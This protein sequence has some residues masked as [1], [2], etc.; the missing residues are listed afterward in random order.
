MFIDKYIQVPETSA[1]EIFLKSLVDV[2]LK[3]TRKLGMAVNGGL[4]MGENIDCQIKEVVTAAA[5]T[6]V[7]VSHTLKR[8][9]TG[10]MV[11]N[12]DK[13]AIIYA[14]GTAWT[15]TNIYIKS[16]AATTTVK[17]LIF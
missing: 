5:N 6:E 11:V 4:K 9:P 15:A 7:A 10:F 8:T 1:P 3:Y 14:S 2:L 17:L 12:L 13:A 16:N